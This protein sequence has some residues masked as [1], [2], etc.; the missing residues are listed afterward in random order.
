MP[1]KSDFDGETV[2][3]LP[4]DYLQSALA[5]SE[6]YEEELAARV[7]NLEVD[8]LS[9]KPGFFRGT[10]LATLLWMVP[11]IWTVCL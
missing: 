7:S 8:S 3:V 5:V 10:L 6:I 11:A 1:S 2:I 4:K 9:G